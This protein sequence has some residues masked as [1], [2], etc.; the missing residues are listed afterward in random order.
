M[1]RFIIIFYLVIIF[2]NLPP[3]EAE[4][5]KLP[6]PFKSSEACDNYQSVNCRVDSFIY[7]LK[8]KTNTKL[9][10]RFKPLDDKIAFVI[11]AGEVFVSLDHDLYTMSSKP[12]LMTQEI[13]NEMLDHGNEIDIKDK[14]FANGSLVYPLYDKGEGWHVFWSQ[15][16]VFSVFGFSK[17]QSPETQL[18]IKVGY[19]GKV[20]WWEKSVIF[21]ECEGL[22]EGNCPESSEYQ[23]AESGQ[24]N[25]VKC[26]EPNK[27]KTCFSLVLPTE[28]E[29]LAAVKNILEDCHCKKRYAGFI[30]QSNYIQIIDEGIQS[31]T[32]KAIAREIRF[33]FINDKWQ[34][35][36]DILDK[37]GKIAPGSIKELH[38]CLPG[39][40]GEDFN[41]EPCF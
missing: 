29:A 7:R 20:G 24:Q 40:G 35:D 41:S 14:I 6:L 25:E 33:L 23:D 9:H 13:R 4:V 31:Q 2:F 30:P 26:E 22:I 32:V 12:F 18:W 28:E 17:F 27:G 11:P 8:Y 39:F 21:Q 34:V 1:S 3:A 19:K 38:Q 10:V 5:T 15:G 36:P 16:K 37:N